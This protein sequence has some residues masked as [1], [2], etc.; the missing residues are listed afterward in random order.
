M[1]A[2]ERGSI[3]MDKIGRNDPCP[4]G[5][6]K[7]YKRCCLNEDGA[8]SGFAVDDRN[9]ALAKLDRFVEKELGKEDEAA[10]DDF[11][12]PWE[13]RIEELD[14]QQTATSESVFDMWFFCDA[15]LSKGGR[16]IDLFLEEGPLLSPGE[17]RY[18]RLLRE[19]AL[20][21]YEVED[22][23]PGVS[24]TLVELT[25]GTRLKV[26]EHLGSRSLWR[27]A[28][29]AAR[30]ISEGPCGQPEIESGLLNI[31]ELSRDRVLAQLSEERKEYQREHPGAGDADFFKDMGSFFHDVWI[32]SILDPQIPHM[33]NTDGEDLLTTRVRFDVLDSAAVEAAFAETKELDRD[34][35]EQA[36]NWLGN[37][38]KGDSIILG[39]LVLH[40][41]SL[42]LESN[43]VRRGERGRALIEKLAGDC[44]RHRST[45]HEN[46]AAGIREALRS[47]NTGK[48]SNAAEGEDAI[49]REVQEALTLDAQA[50]HYREWIDIPIPA[51][52]DRTPRDAA[53]DAALR[54]KVADLIRDLE[55]FYQRALMEGK[56]AYDPSWMWSELEL[57]DRSE[58][59]HPPP[60]G[61][62][63]LASMAPGLEEMCCTVAER[64]RH[65][66]GFDD[67]STVFRP[68]TSGT[69]SKSDDFF[70]RPK[71]KRMTGRRQANLSAR[72]SNGTFPF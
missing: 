53:R 9:S 65:K 72:R 47:G 23:S 19:T 17:R 26:R 52:Q 31:P 13:D 71:P 28:L 55:G 50:R 5:S 41:D 24:V 37:N 67:V 45:V 4:C 6:G 30:I 27:H 1:Q 57:I 2:K 38:Q 56:P 29:L 68:K 8:R 11:Y 21:L 40:G 49:P 69:I 10:Y 66:P 12:E 51:L 25:A 64:L 60:L 32:S 15:R 36:W 54:P 44:V 22:M 20:R 33:Q 16:V 46:V 70:I 34:E 18:L 39:S 7:K 59:V 63:R 3:V 58:P 42:E 61:H 48:S 14:E 35:K 62:E 43:S